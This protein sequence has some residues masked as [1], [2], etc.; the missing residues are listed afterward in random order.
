MLLQIAQFT[1]DTYTTVFLIY[2][3]HKFSGEEKCAKIHDNILGKKVSSIVFI[4][5][6]KLVQEAYKKGLAYDEEKEQ[7]VR[8]RA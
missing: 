7:E 5:N 2:V 8:A 1:W 6:R 4:K 3:I